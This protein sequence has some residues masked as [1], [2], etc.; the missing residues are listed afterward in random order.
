MRVSANK[1]SL[2]LSLNLHLSAAVASSTPPLPPSHPL[3]PPS[4]THPTCPPS[5]QTHCSVAPLIPSPPQTTT[6][7]PHPP[8]PHNTLL[9]LPYPTNRKTHLCRCRKGIRLPTKPRDLL[10][11]GFRT[12]AHHH[13]RIHPQVSMAR[14][15]RGVEVEVEV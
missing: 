1:P 13:R 12:R 6:L 3:L 14:K 4:P 8:T 2:A 7:Q 5:Q 15:W 11:Q 10:I 9:L